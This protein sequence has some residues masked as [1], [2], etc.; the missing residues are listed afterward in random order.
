VAFGGDAEGLFAAHVEFTD[1]GEEPMSLKTEMR[2]TDFRETTEN[3]DETKS[4]PLTHWVNPFEADSLSV[5][6]LFSESYP[7]PSMKSVVVPPRI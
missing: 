7:C 2:T 5:T 1:Q 4:K 6:R 3:A